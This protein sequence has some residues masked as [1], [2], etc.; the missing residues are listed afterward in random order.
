MKNFLKVVLFGL[1]TIGFFA[2]FANFGI[3]RI[4]PAPPPTEEKLDLSA[5]TMEGFIALG[6]RVF[7]GKGTCTLCHNAL[8][9]RAPMLDR[10]ALV[11]EERL[12]DAR[13]KG[14]AT[15]AATYL[16]ESMVEPSA[17]VVVGF[18]KAGS[19]DSESPMPNA[20]AGSIGLSEAELTAVIAYLQELSGVEISVEVP[21]DVE[22]EA[23][24][25]ADSV[26][27]ASAPATPLTTGEE[28]ISK[29]ACGACH[30]I[31]D[32]VGA[33]GPDLTSIG[34]TRDREYLRR[35]ILDPN[36]DVAEGFMANM[37]PAIYANQL[38]ASELE[39]LVDYLAAQK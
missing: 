32:Q 7:N 35:S 21:A 2:G 12:Q 37:M 17:F 31:A 20:A 9:G 10:A 24:P 22:E 16:Y 30:K 15:D 23:A 34:A 28:I 29:H 33:L 13:Y 26:A 36:A 25:E 4:E 1:L 39:V 18:G 19:S 6:D 14:K 5:M 8:G 3:P 11:A 38:Y 27:A